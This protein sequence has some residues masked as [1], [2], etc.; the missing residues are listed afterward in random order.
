MFRADG[1]RAIW[2]PRNGEHHWITADMGGRWQQVKGL[3]KTAVVEADRVDEGIYYAGI[4]C[5]CVNDTTSKLVVLDARTSDAIA[6]GIKFRC[7]IFCVEKILDEASYNDERSDE[8]DDEE[9]PGQLVDDLIEPTANVASN[10]GFSKFPMEELEQMLEDAIND[11]DYGKAAKI[12]D[13][14]KRRNG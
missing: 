5:L 7:P 4:T 12:R 9:T 1:K 11:E 10:T 13:E 2:H 3:P 8:F 14:I 6:M